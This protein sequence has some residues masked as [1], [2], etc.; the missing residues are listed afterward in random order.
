MSPT[1]SARPVSAEACWDPAPEASGAWRSTTVVVFPVSIAPVATSTAASTA[2]TRPPTTPANTFD[3]P[4]TTADGRDGLLIRRKTRVRRDCA[5]PA[6]PRDRSAP[7][8]EGSAERSLVA[9]ARWRA[10]AGSCVALLAQ[11]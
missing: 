2:T 1:V 10:G 4:F 11:Q 3:R 7:I 5:Q 9:G 6:Q 8:R